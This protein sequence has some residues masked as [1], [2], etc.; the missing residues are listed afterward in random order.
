[1]SGRD[2]GVAWGWGGRV[3]VPARWVAG[4]ARVAVR[5]AGLAGW[6]LACLA[7]WRAGGLLLLAARRWEHRWRRAMVKTWAGGVAWTIGMRIEARGPA[8]APPFIMVTNH[9][10]YMDVILLASDLG[11]CFVAKR[12]LRSW[13]F[14]GWLAASAGTV[15]V[16]RANKRDAVRVMGSMAELVRRGD[17]VVVFPEGTSTKGDEVYPMKPALLDVA[18][19]S[20]MAVRYASLSYRTPAGEPPAHLAVCWWG[21]M[22]FGR[23]ALELCRLPRFDATVV[24]GEE[25]IVESDRKRL[26]V[27][28]REAIA[29]GFTPVVPA[30]GQQAER[31]HG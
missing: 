29:E 5:V 1:M 20:G 4:Q 17:G 24:Y 28:L 14:L 11:C 13:P 31:Q 30:D 15:F 19:R 25:A 16:D 6:T 8:P 3:T 18:A 22:T 7:V 21:D 26:A 9:L 12:E 2:V 27:R 10:S 23:H